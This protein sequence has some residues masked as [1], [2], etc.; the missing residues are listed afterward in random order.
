MTVQ[1]L[2]DRLKE[3]PSDMRVATESFPFDDI[4]IRITRYEYEKHS[5][6]D[7]DFDYIELI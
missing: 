4:E 6:K 3:F 7:K 2:I 1:E 5:M